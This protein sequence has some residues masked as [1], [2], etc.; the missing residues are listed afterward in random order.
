MAQALVIK[1]DCIKNV[2]VQDG[3]EVRGQYQECKLKYLFNQFT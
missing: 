1:D 3:S 2:P